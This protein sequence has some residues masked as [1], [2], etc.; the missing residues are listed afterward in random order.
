MNTLKF[1]AVDSSLDSG[2]DVV[3][4]Y[5]L[6]EERLLP[7]FDPDND[8]SGSPSSFA[9]RVSSW[10]RRLFNNLF[11]GRSAAAVAD[12]A[13]APEPSMVG[14]D[15]I[16]S[17]KVGEPEAE[18]SEA[19]VELPTVAFAAP[20]AEAVGQRLPKPEQREFRFAHVTVICN[21]LHDADIEIVST[22]RRR[23]P[24]AVTGPQVAVH[25]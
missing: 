10:W 23:P 22:S 14:A 2:R 6:R 7:R 21:D 4:R 11:G 24:A 9:A 5:R 17:S 13:P 12:P 3:G 19:V 18:T 16:G 8:A 15:A 20:A 1:L 25:A